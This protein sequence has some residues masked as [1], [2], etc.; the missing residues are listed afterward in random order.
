MKLYKDL[1]RKI[2]IERIF[3]DYE[4]TNEIGGSYA[5]LPLFHL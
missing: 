1:V 2:K 3:G 4:N 5:R